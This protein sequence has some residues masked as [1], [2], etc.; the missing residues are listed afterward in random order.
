M[1][2]EE[3]RHNL[4]GRRR[5]DRDQENITNCPLNNVIV[6]HTAISIIAISRKTHRNR[7]YILY[8][9][10][11]DAPFVFMNTCGGGV[12][13]CGQTLAANGRSVAIFMSSRERGAVDRTCA[14]VDRWAHFEDVYTSSH[15]N[16]K[17]K[18]QQPPN[19]SRL[20]APS[21]TQCNANTIIVIIIII[22]PRRHIARPDQYGLSLSLYLIADD[23]KRVSMHRW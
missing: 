14:R 13:G 12:G 9:F 18:R 11:D 15:T 4:F 10:S 7:I 16:N 17:K 1:Y 3:S 21:T 5:H 6:L 22:P 19:N 23:G 2:P 20:R 8:L